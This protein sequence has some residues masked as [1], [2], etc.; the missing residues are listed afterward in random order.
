MVKTNLEQKTCA[1][2]KWKRYIHRNP[3]FYNNLFVLRSVC[4]SPGVLSKNDITRLI[5]SYNLPRIYKAYFTS[6]YRLP[7]VPEDSD[8][9]SDETIYYE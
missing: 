4:D 1:F 3:R 5:D 9:D 7:W 6:T 8:Y 2:E